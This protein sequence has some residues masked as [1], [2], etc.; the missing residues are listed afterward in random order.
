VSSAD[1]DENEDE[2]ETEE[3][4]VIKEELDLVATT[5]TLLHLCQLEPRLHLLLHYFLPLPTS[6]SP[7]TPRR[8]HRLL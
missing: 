6:P 8:S 2:V 1:E 5:L 4:M 3:E 7:A